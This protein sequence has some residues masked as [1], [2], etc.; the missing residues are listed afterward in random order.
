MYRINLDTIG[1]QSLTWVRNV[2]EK[3]VTCDTAATLASLW[4]RGLENDYFFET[5]GVL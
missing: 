5:C 2:V 1:L 4:S 3:D